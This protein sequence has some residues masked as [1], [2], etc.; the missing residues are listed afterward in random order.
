MA[1]CLPRAILPFEFGIAT[2]MSVVFLFA[3]GV[4]VTSAE[5]MMVM[6]ARKREKNEKKKNATSG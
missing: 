5:V 3:L 2:G 6:L 4:Y 1:L